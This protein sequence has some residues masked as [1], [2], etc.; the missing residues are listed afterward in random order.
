VLHSLFVIKLFV[1]SCSV[2]QQCLHIDSLSVQLFRS[3]GHLS[4]IDVT[5]VWS[6]GHF[7]HIRQ[8]RVCTCMAVICAVTQSHTAWEC[9]TSDSHWTHT[10]TDILQRLCHVSG[11]SVCRRGGPVSVPDQTVWDLWWT[12]WH[13]DSFFS[14]YF[15]FSVSIMPVLYTHS[16]IHPSLMVYNV[17]NWLTNS[18]EQRPSW[19]A[20]RSSA[21]QEIPR[22]LWT[23]RFSTAIT[24][25]RHLFLSWAIS[26]QSKPSHPISWRSI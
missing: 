15:S 9:V 5:V 22:V 20:N 3:T 26:I 4:C 7:T 8:Y 19:E 25:T 18:M 1:L 10:T 17:C 14:E 12:K 21:S 24:R 23:R 16:F 6:V 2:A 13:Q 11:S